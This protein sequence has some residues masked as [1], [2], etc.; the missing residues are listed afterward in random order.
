MLTYI[1][2]GEKYQQAF[3][4]FEE[5]AQA[6]ATSSIQSLIS[7]AVAEIHLGRLD[8]A[9]AALQ[10]AAAKDPKQ[11]DLIAN[12]IVLNIIAGKDTAELKRF[13]TFR[14]I[15]LHLLTFSHL[16]LCQVLLQIIITSKTSKRRAHYSTRLQ[17]NTLQRLQLEIPRDDY[18]VAF[19]GMMGFTQFMSLKN[20]IF[21][22]L[23][24]ECEVRSSSQGECFGQF[25]C[26]DVI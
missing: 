16:V 4:V 11:A 12:N 14:T 5:L 9:E 8:E 15:L 1:Q 20:G 26:C 18:N 7:Q 6:P 24:L 23:V 13:V 2:G 25:S 3:Y 10:Q 21:S 22:Q 17:Q 19:I